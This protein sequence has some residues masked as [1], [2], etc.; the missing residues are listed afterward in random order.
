MMHND[1]IAHIYMQ[2]QSDAKD[3]QVQA[4]PINGVVCARCVAWR[5][6]DGLLC[7][8]CA[9]HCHWRVLACAHDAIPIAIVEIKCRRCVPRPARSP[10]RPRLCVCLCANKESRD[11]CCVA[12]LGGRT[13]MVRFG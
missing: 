6:C 2:S 3:M 12:G 11:Q 4:E 1:I 7:A 13:G 10:T 5:M 9:V 8:G